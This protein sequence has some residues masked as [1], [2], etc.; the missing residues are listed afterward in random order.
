MKIDMLNDMGSSGINASV[1]GENAGDVSG[2]IDFTNIIEQAL[3]DVNHKIV[4]SESMAEKMAAGRSVDIAQAM[5]AITKADLAFRM[6][7]QVRN[8]ALSA[9]EE[10]MRMQV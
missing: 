2:K 9:Y 10:I 3:N 7:M 6:T 8:K 1:K 4:A 5:T